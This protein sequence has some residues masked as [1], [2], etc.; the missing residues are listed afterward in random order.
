MKSSAQQPWDIYTILKLL[1]LKFGAIVKTTH[2]QNLPA[3]KARFGILKNEFTLKPISMKTNL[4]KVQVQQINQNSHL[5][6]C[7]YK[8]EDIT[9]K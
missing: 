4:I 9:S 5:P 8:S 6:L 3:L 2:F 7:P 1:L